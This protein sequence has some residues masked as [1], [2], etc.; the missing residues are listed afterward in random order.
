MFFYNEKTH[1][2][3]YQLV[4]DGIGEE[5]KLPQLKMVNNEAYADN[6]YVKY[7]VDI[8]K[9][10]KGSTPDPDDSNELWRMFVDWNGFKDLATKQAG[11]LA[12]FIDVVHPKLCKEYV[13]PTAMACWKEDCDNAMPPIETPEDYEIDCNA[14][15]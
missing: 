9:F 10:E 15:P 5:G 7:P 2:F 3:V 13:S 11:R 14:I 6:I 12:A 1:R 8:V 4:C